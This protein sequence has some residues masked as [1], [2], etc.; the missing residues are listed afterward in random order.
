MSSDRK[1]AQQASAWGEYRLR[2]LV[3]NVEDYA[4]HIANTDGI[5][6]TWNI[7]AEKLFGYSAEEAIGQHSRLIFT[8]EDRTKGIPEDEMM[9]ARA[10]GSAVDERW[11]QRKDGSRFFASG[12]Q[13]ALYENGE[14]TG[15]AKI[16]RD[17]TER[18][19]LEEQLRSLNESLDL[20]V[21]QQ[22]SALHKEIAERKNAEQGRVQLLRKIVTTQEDERKRI[23]R[24]LHDHLG[25]KLI[26]LKLNLELVRQK[27]DDDGLC[28]L[29]EQAQEKTKEIDA[30]LDFLA[31][32]LRPASIDELGLEVT[33]N[34]F[35]KEF[36]DHFKIPSEFHSTGL[37][38]KRL[39]PE[40]EINLY[41]IAQEALNNIAK[42]AKAT[43][44]SVMLKQ[45]DHKITLIVEDNG[46]G[47]TPQ[48][49]ANRRKGLGLV[50]M[51]ERI[52]LIGG[53]VE[54]ESKKGAGTTIYAR[55]P[56]R[57]TREEDE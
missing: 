8:P 45:P 32:E 36:S 25:Q 43:N 57:F 52:A 29:I 48:E 24:D 41:R 28:S 34:N 15:Y 9:Q 23:S 5:I 50:G 21:E 12:F 56:A 38:G 22:T 47:F 35:V 17:L 7:G 40:I 4:I 26:A 16:A 39:S 14:L 49:K 20:K 10:N 27:C 13:T 2:Q 44:V 1:Q 3:E 30:E 51:A 42:H 33:V 19:K 18:I 6:E 53:E 31:W 55:V 37:K 54:I 11:H 46:V